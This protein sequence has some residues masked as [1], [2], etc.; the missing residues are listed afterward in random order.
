MHRTTQW[1]I[2]FLDQD[3][4]QDYKSE[5]L[6]G[7]LANYFTTIVIFI[8]CLG[9]FGLVSFTAE[10]KTKEIGIRKVLGANLSQVVAL[11][12][13]EFM[14]LVFVA[15]VVAAPIAWYLMNQWLEDFYYKISLEPWIFAGA[16]VA[17]I[18]IALVTVSYQAI[19]AGLTNPVDALRN[20]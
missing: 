15:L 8:S 18:S 10:R 14:P 17:S 19:K 12:S 7:K 1:I 2:P 16:A 6:I 3:F 5:M 4:E 9:L 13:R 20:E 11:I